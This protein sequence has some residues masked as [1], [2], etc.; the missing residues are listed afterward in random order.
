M[1]TTT[2]FMLSSVAIGSILALGAP[3]CAAPPTKVWVASTGVD[4]AS[5]GTVTAPCRT[6]VGAEVNVAA[7]GEIGVLTPGDYGDPSFATFITKS[8]AL[9]NDGI[10]EAGIQRGDGTALALFAGNGDI[11]SLRGLTFDGVIGGNVGIEI[12]HNMSAVHI[13][14]CV[15]KNFQSP[16]F[17][18]L[19]HSTIGQLLISDTLIYNNG[20]IA[21]TGGIVLRGN[22]NVT[23]DRVHLENNVV[24]LLADGTDDTDTTV[25]GIF[26]VVRDSVAAANAA[27]GIFARTKAGR[28]PA[29]MVVERGTSVNNAGSGIHADGPGATVLLSD[30]TI[31]RNGAG[32]ST[33]NGGQLISYGNNRNN[34]NVGP[35]GVPTGFFGLF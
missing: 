35:E 28:G 22:V 6:F 5:C 18:I 11:V 1:T 4:N 29:F 19:N 27:D 7:G 26:V 14:N 21:G 12:L 16:G 17:G 2:K 31:S 20:S 24:G 33:A 32:V 9:T 13:Q 8:L 34:N 10:G 23:L 25:K 30:S 15:I 3:A